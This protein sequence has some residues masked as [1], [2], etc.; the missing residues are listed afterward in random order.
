MK[1]KLASKVAVVAIL[2]GAIIMATRAQVP[3]STING[4]V[5]DPGQAVV[6]GARISV[7]DVA[8]GA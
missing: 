1:K 7:T 8:T 4:I 2:V 3:T 6:T 5:T